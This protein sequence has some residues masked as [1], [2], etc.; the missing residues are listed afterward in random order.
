MFRFGPG[1]C[2]GSSGPELS[3]LL[4]ALDLPITGA[5]PSLGGEQGSGRG[6][7]LTGPG[8]PSS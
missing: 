5:G 7:V 8:L 4:W 2:E 3:G 1:A 6:P